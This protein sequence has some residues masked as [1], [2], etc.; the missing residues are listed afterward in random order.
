MS[1][2]G[3]G[4]VRSAD[5]GVCSQGE[6]PA[7]GQEES[8]LRRHAISHTHPGCSTFPGKSQTHFAVRVP[9]YDAQFIQFF[10]GAGNFLFPPKLV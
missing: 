10:G 6:L 1:G 5:T 4:R 2:A 7:A 9:P 8:V 3:A